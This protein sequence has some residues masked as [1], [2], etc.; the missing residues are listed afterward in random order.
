[1]PESIKERSMTRIKFCILSVVAMTSAAVL[2]SVSDAYPGKFQVAWGKTVYVSLA[3]GA[4]GEV[5]PTF[6]K[7]QPKS[8]PF[9]SFALSEIARIRTLVVTNN[10]DKELVYKARMCVVGERL[11][12]SGTIMSVKAGISSSKLRDA[13]VYAVE[14][15]AL[16][17]E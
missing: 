15:T 4:D 9:I 13:S 5:T 2:A 7:T 16:S 17:L 6:Y 3:S 12:E 1:L 8:G 14:V 10:Y 11:C